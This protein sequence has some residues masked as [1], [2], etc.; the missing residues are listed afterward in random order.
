MPSSRVY[1][2]MVDVSENATTFPTRVSW[3]NTIHQSLSAQA[4]G[5][6]VVSGPR[7]FMLVRSAYEYQ[8]DKYDIRRLTILTNIYYDD[9]LDESAAFQRAL[10]M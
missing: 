3:Y 4:S 6:V 8:R 2:I 7:F 9:R 5:D 1:D 10:S